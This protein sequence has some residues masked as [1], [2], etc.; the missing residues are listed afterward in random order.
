VSPREGLRQAGISP[1]RRP[2]TLEVVEIA[3]LSD[4]FTKVL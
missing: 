4:V 1:T 2:Q 3:R